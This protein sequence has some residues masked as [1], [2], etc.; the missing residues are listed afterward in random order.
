MEADIRRVCNEIADMLVEK[1]RKYGNSAIHPVRIFSSASPLEQLKVRI[2]DKLSRVK[3]Q[4]L[5]ED[6]DVIDD[7][8]GYFVLLKIGIMLEQARQTEITSEIISQTDTPRFNQGGIVPGLQII[9]EEPI[10][11]QGTGHPYYKQFKKGS[12]A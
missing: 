10:I 9:S 2:D 7:L 5:D 1:N 11:G 4:Q 6:E 12:Y 8:I 3:N